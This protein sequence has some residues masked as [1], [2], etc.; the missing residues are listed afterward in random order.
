MPNSYFFKSDLVFALKLIFL[1]SFILKVIDKKN[2]PIVFSFSLAFFFKQRFS[3]YF[4]AFWM[5]S[6]KF[7]W[8][9][10]YIS[11]TN[12]FHWS[13][14]FKAISWNLIFSRNVVNIKVPSFRICLWF[15]LVALTLDSFIRHGGFCNNE[16]LSSKKTWKSFLHHQWIIL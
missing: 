9:I 5:K 4:F 1:S 7:Y 15:S 6:S 11:E 12:S 14:L 3:F 13:T 8:Y 10:G 2:R 16:L